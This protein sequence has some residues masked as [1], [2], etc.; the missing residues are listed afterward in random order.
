MVDLLVCVDVVVWP[1]RVP[2]L[3]SP[4]PPEEAGA[5]GG[6]DGEDKDVDD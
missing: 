2:I 4:P 5:G 3:I 1:V 6:L